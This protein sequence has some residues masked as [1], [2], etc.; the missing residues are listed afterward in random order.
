MKIGGFNLNM[1]N[2]LPKYK[3]AVT[4]D[5]VFLYIKYHYQDENENR[6]TQIFSRKIELQ[7]IYK[8]AWLMLI[9]TGKCVSATLMSG[10][11]HI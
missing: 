9:E 6:R 4:C 10:L 5:K 8:L 7:H 1:R 2:S 3:S 11:V